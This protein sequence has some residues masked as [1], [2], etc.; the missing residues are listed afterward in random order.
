MHLKLTQYCKSIFKKSDFLFLLEDS[1]SGNTDPNLTWPQC[2]SWETTIFSSYINCLV[3]FPQLLIGICICTPLS[4][5]LFC[6][7]GYSLIW[8]TWHINS[9]LSKGNKYLLKSQWRFLCPSYLLLLPHTLF[10]LCFVFLSFYTSNYLSLFTFYGRF[11]VERKFPRGR[12][13]SFLFTVAVP[14][15]REVSCCE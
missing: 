4:P 1:R 7:F 12:Y 11:S 10:I 14:V 9:V 15:P 6:A 5:A 13:L 8:W 2:W 3:Y